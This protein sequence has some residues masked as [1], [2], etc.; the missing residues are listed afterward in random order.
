MKKLRYW[1]R[2]WCAW[3]GHQEAEWSPV[4]LCWRTPD[5]WDGERVIDGAETRVKAYRCERHDKEK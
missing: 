4:V 1:R 3:R 2:R 5:V